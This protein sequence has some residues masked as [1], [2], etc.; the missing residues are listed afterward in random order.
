MDTSKDYPHDEVKARKLWEKGLERNGKAI[1]K[2]LRKVLT[3]KKQFHFDETPYSY[4]VEE[5]ELFDIWD[6]RS[7]LGIL[8]DEMTDRIVVLDMTLNIDDG[9]YYGQTTITLSINVDDNDFQVIRTVGTL[10]KEQATSILSTK[11]QVKK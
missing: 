2:Y 8:F 6:T 7:L 11:I 9:T 4:E 10:T 5:I 3:V 1:S